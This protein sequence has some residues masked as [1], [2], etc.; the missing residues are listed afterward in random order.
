[1]RLLGTIVIFLVGLGVGIGMHLSGMLP[2]DTFSYWPSSWWSSS[3][4]VVTT[5]PPP[6]P[7][8]PYPTNSTYP[9]TVYP[10]DKPADYAPP[11]PPVG[12]APAYVPPGPSPGSLRLVVRCN[13]RPDDMPYGCG[14]AYT[15]V[16]RTPRALYVTFEGGDTQFERANAPITIAPGQSVGGNEE[17]RNG[18]RNGYGGDDLGAPPPF[19]IEIGDCDGACAN[20]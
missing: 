10:A 13:V 11:P 6:E 7:V 9:N 4:P 17:L 2:T 8:T 16:N 15:L 12:D 5:A 20:Y 3:A 18:Y 19:V 14:A 1:M